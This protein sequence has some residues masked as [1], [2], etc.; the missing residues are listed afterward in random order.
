VVW[1]NGAFGVGKTT[2]ANALAVFRSDLRIFDPETVGVML[3]PNLRDQPVDDFQDW[4]AWRRLVVATARELIAQTGQS[5]IAP[6]TVLSQTYWTEIR[7]SLEHAG[8]RIVHVLL[9]CDA[10]TLMARAGSSDAA[11]QW[12]LEH[13]EPY[14]ESRELWLLAEADLVINLAEAG[15]EEAAQAIAAAL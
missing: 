9:D 1:L 13:I 8:T 2:T 7:A 14:R 11:L 10:Q 6:Q 3:Q 12:R 15:A 5:L 4:P